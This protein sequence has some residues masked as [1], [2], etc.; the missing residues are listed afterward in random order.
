MR[1]PI[2][3]IALCL[4]MCA[5]MARAE[6]AV[7]PSTRYRLEIKNNTQSPPLEVPP[8]DSTTEITAGYHR[9]WSIWDAEV[10]CRFDLSAIPSD[11]VISHVSLSVKAASVQNCPEHLRIVEIYK[12]SRSWDGTPVYNDLGYTGWSSADLLIS[13][14]QVPEGWRHYPQNAE[15]RAPVQE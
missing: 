12:N 8:S 6:K 2:I 1:H 10:L 4:L 13:D 7:I 15:L 11:A 5:A 3:P 9:R 14:N